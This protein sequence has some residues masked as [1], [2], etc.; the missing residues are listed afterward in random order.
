M[1]THVN[2][3]RFLTLPGPLEAPTSQD[4]ANHRLKSV[5]RTS[6]TLFGGQSGIYGCINQ[7]SRQKWHFLPELHRD[8]GLLTV[9]CTQ[10]GR[11]VSISELC[12]TG[13]QVHHVPPEA[14]EKP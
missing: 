8:M 7:E 11:E 1:A 4:L 12:E 3:F 14:Y 5:L 2:N 13:Q 6:L 10:T 9:S